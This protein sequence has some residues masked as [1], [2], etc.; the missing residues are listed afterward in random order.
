MKIYGLILTVGA[1]LCLGGC[2]SVDTAQVAPGGGE[3]VVMNNFGWKFFDWIPLV[4]G[5]ASEKASAGCVFFRDDVTLDKTQARFQ[6]YA[7]GR[8]VECPMYDVNDTKFISVFGIPI[9]YLITYK[10]ITLSGTMK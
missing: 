4:C 6:K 5:N 3:H 9:P 8:T 10:E 2:F 7:N 1:T